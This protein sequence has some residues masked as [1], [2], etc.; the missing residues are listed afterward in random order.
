MGN[1]DAIWE[2]NLER[3]RCR[4][5]LEAFDPVHGRGCSGDRVEVGPEDWTEGRELIPR[6]M[7]RDPKYPS[8]RTANAW[9]KL[10]C[11]YDFEYWAAKCCYIRDKETCREIPFILNRPQRRVVKLLEADRRAGRPMRMIILKARQWGGSTVVE[12]YIAWIQLVF[13]ELNI[14]ALVCGREKGGSQV[15]LNLYGDMLAR[16]PLE[17]W[18]GE[19][20]PKLKTSRGIIRIEGRENRIYVA[21]STNADAVR[22]VNVGLVHLTEAAY[23]KATRGT[24]PADTVRSIYGAV[25]VAP[26]TLVVMESTAD[27]VGSFFHE[28][29]SRACCGKSDKRP[30]FVPWHEIAKYSLR[31]PPGQEGRRQAQ[32][33]WENLDEYE[34]GLW[35]QQ[36]L[37]LEQIN[38]Y[39]HKRREFTDHMKMKSEFPTTPEEAFTSSASNVFSIE[40]INLLREGCREPIAFG[41]VISLS[42]AL[43]G[44]EALVGVEFSRDPRGAMQ[45]WEMPEK[46]AQYVVAVDVGGLSEKADWSVI[47]V[48]RRGGKPEIAAQ[49][50]AHIDHDLLAWKAAMIAR[51]YNTALLV[52]ESNTLESERRPGEESPS[53]QGAAILNELYYYY[54]ELYRRRA[55]GQG[56]VARIPGFHTNR[57]T[58]S[59]IITELIA[60]VRDG[61]YTERST[62]ACDELAT[63]ERLSNGSYAARAGHHDDILMTRAI[64]L[65]VARELA[66]PAS[67][68]TA[69]DPDLA[70]YLSLYS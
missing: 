21:A 11:R 37:T 3:N 23:W 17:F 12:M 32:T 41:D 34:S 50:R 45:I 67:A 68:D 1:F 55:P 31:F 69:L 2:E 36:G 56:S 15:V 14:D 24:D 13:R 20:A 6:E 62:D 5:R 29:W 70:S 42:G 38:W 57:Q 35:H 28:E 48:I 9:T 10:R 27:G 65:H 46:G 25:A 61:R 43:T 60:A 19:K 44:P 30:V 7:L 8:A 18:E 33:L 59:M 49:W 16:Y 54:P 22:G 53:R 64:G 47:A 63:Y 58:K 66:P 4:D 52:F 40:K 26:M 39:R 51:L